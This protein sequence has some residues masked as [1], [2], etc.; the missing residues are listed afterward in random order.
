MVFSQ[1]SDIWLSSVL[2]LDHKTPG[3]SCFTHLSHDVQLKDG[4]FLFSLSPCGLPWL[5]AWGHKLA[6]ITAIVPFIHPQLSWTVRVKTSRRLSHSS[7]PLFFYILKTPSVFKNTITKFCVCD[8]RC[9]S[10]YIFSFVLWWHQ[11]WH[12]SSIKG[13][14]TSCFIWPC[15]CFTLQSLIFL[16]CVSA[17]GLGLSLLVLSVYLTCLFRCQRKE[18][19][20]VKRPET[21]CVTW[22]AVITGLVIWWVKS[23]LCF[24]STG[25]CVVLYVMTDFIH[26]LPLVNNNAFVNTNTFSL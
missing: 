15:V 5:R 7:V 24:V 10:I 8:I 3:L 26:S 17:I 18:D 22:V 12:Q 6:L 11:R 21:C 14:S 19:E 25:A 23:R 4:S 16:A 20:E 9:S 13:R 2:L 1:P